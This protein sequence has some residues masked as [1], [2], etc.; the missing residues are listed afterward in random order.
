MCFF[1]WTPLW[2]IPVGLLA[3]LPLHALGQIHW[4]NAPAIGLEPQSN[5]AAA[6]N[7]QS[8]L[9]VPSADPE[10]RQ[11]RREQRDKAEDRQK[12]ASTPTVAADG[13]FISGTVTTVNGDI[14]VGAKILLH[15]LNSNESRSAV[16]SE[17]GAFQFEGLDPSSPYRITIETVGLQTWESEDILLTPGQYFIL[18][19]I[20]LKMP[21]VVTSVSVHGSREQIAAEQVEIQQRQRVFGFIPNFYVTYDPNP[22]ALTTKLKFKLAAKADTDP[23]TF[24]GVAF[25]AGM[26]QAGDMLDYGQGSEGF[27]KRMV[28][29]YA[30]TTSNIFMGGAVLPWLFRQDPRYFY[31]GTGSKRARVLHALTSPYVCKGDNGKTQPNYSSLGG[32]LVS[33]AISNIYYPKSNRGPGLVLQGFLI[34]TGVRTVNALLQEFLIRKL[35]PSA[36]R[37]SLERSSHRGIVSDN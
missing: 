12:E 9:D 14:V 8:A 30:D 11:I 36:R 28:A 33:G 17:T 4:F 25:M 37:N 18:T 15:K 5:F 16:A 35:T 29:G 32:D 3:A 26:Y 23:V 19:K 24:V 10:E 2:A 13:A 7:V 1:R 27:A 22:V 6:A 31:L 34:T 20:Q 21:E